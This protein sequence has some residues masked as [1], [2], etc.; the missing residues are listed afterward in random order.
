MEALDPL[1]YLVLFFAGVA[2]WIIGKRRLWGDLPLLLL[3][4]LVGG[5]AIG[6]LALEGFQ[7]QLSA[8]GAL[9]LGLPLQL[10]SGTGRHAELARVRGQ[11]RRSAWWA[12][13]HWFV[14]P[15][16]RAWHRWRTWRLVVKAREEAVAPEDAA[17]ILLERQRRLEAREAPHNLGTLWPMY[18]LTW[19]AVSAIMLPLEDE[20]EDWFVERAEAIRDGAYAAPG[21]TS[22]ACERMLE[23]GLVAQ[24]AAVVDAMNRVEPPDG[25]SLDR[26]Q[27]FRNRARLLLLAHAGREAPLQAALA[28]GAMHRGLF[29]RAQRRALRDRAGQPPGAPDL[30]VTPDFG[31]IL[32]ESERGLAS[33]AVLSTQIAERAPPPATAA[34]MGLILLTFLGQV[35]AGATMDPQR[36]EA[37]GALSL[38]RVQAGEGWRVV[39]AMLLHAGA[40]HLFLN[41]LFLWQFGAILERLV[42]PWRLLGVFLFAGLVG[43]LA[44]LPTTADGRVLVGASGAIFGVFGACAPAIWR[45]TDPRARRWRRGQLAGLAVVTVLNL[46]LGLSLE[47]VSGAAHLWGAV[48]GALAWGLMEVG[49]RRA[50]ALVPGLAAAGWLAA[51]GWGGW[52]LSGTADLA[53]LRAEKAAER[54]AAEAAERG[55]EALAAGRTAEAAALLA[56]AVE[57]SPGDP[58][59]NVLYAEALV[60]EGRRGEAHAPLERADAAFVRMAEV[61]PGIAP[62]WTN[63]GWVAW[64][65]G[66][67]EDCVAYSREAL[68]IDPEEVV[69]SYNLGLCLVGL[70][71][72]E[73]ALVAYRVASGL[74]EH[75]IGVAELRA[76]AVDPG[77]SEA[78][79]V[80]AGRVLEEVFGG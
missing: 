61:S 13:A 33:E 58:M 10:L 22:L 71:R 8:A 6:G 56:V 54:A 36:L 38:A 5:L 43:N 7:A 32:E 66:R 47:F 64:L 65:D 30:S 62:A 79:R 17:A 37:L 15:N 51:L 16:A 52:G 46:Y 63:R 42:G 39:T 12:A 35:W 14:H 3:T 27:A 80:V 9:L 77:A 59:L 55:Q 49:G 53:A 70:G 11:H 18:S 41:G 20:L 23:E 19:D 76:L 25:E 45:I 44:A 2:A 50:G 34:L 72:Y 40:A 4:L 57:A 21:A 31:A 69:A 73:E 68:A 78:A 75:A 26:Y 24:A 67:G 48:G 60:A 1:L 74:E 28:P 29:T